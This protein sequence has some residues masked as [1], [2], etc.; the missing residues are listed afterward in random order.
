MD[1]ATVD[2]AV[3]GA[4]LQ[5]SPADLAGVFVLIPTF[6]DISVRQERDQLSVC[7][8]GVE[9]EDEAAPTKK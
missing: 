6:A 7:S 3:S 1:E 8:G 4:D 5:L 2:L 9:H